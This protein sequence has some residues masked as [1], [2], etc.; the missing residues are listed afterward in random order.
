MTGQELQKRARKKRI[1]WKEG[2]SGDGIEG[3][4]KMRKEKWQ[5]I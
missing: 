1:S 5:R 4:N 3:G 2:G